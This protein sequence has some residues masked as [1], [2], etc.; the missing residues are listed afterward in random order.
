MKRIVLTN[1]AVSRS[2]YL[3]IQ[4]NSN[5]SGSGLTNLSATSTGLVCT[6]TRA[7]TNP[8]I[9]SLIALSTATSAWV[10]GGFSEVSQLGIPGLYRL[11]VPD[12]AF[13]TG[14][15]KCVVE[16]HGN[17]LMVPL[18]AEYQLDTDLGFDKAFGITCRGTVA[19]WSGSG[20]TNGKLGTVTS[21]AITDVQAGDILK[22]AGLPA[23]ILKTMD[24]STGSYTVGTAF[25]SSASSLGFLVF[26]SAPG[27]ATQPVFANISQVSGTTIK[28]VGSDAD[29]WQAV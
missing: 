17:A 9:V 21:G 25:A 22:P 27:E 8:S 16:L 29:P 15:D 28:G 19:L 20:T 23:R 5:L 4:N 10:S 13:A 6:Y 11:D 18:M 3:F 12:A 7:V 24:T 2:E 14:V 1:S 26:G